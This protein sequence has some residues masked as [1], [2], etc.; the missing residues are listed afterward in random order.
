MNQ[1]YL[2]QRRPLMLTF[3]FAVAAYLAVGL[4]Q[5]FQ[6]LVNHDIFVQQ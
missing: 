4:V 5:N 6:K 2:K 1:D 3:N